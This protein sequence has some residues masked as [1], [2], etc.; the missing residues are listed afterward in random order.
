ME[1]LASTPRQLP[2][3]VYPNCRLSVIHAVRKR[4]LHYVY[5]SSGY[6]SDVSVP[7]QP[8]SPGP[9]PEELPRSAQAGHGSAPHSANPALTKF[10]VWRSPRGSMASSAMQLGVIALAGIGVSCPLS[11]SIPA[12]PCQERT[13]GFQSRE[14]R[15]PYCVAPAVQAQFGLL[16][17]SSN[18]GCLA[19][20]SPPF[21]HHD[22][23]KQPCQTRLG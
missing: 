19:G 9:C 17:D 13:S 3:A 22:N 11:G 8:K 18:A 4:R 10:K 16:H 21:W 6:K 7:V 20:S 23:G 14:R 1:S 2:H 12:Q 15:L 5:L